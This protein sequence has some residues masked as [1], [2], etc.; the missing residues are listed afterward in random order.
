M[1][2]EQLATLVSSLQN[3]ER[4]TIEPMPEV[5]HP[6][7][8][9]SESPRFVTVNTRAGDIVVE[10]P[11][12]RPSTWMTSDEFD[13]LPSIPSELDCADYT[14]AGIRHQELFTIHHYVP[15]I[16]ELVRLEK[17]SETSNCLGVLIASDINGFETDMAIGIFPTAGGSKEHE[18]IMAHLPCTTHQAMWNSPDLDELYEITG[19]V[20][21]RYITIRKVESVVP[22]TE[23]EIETTE[24]EIFVDEVDVATLDLETL[25][26]TASTPEEAR[27]VFSAEM[28]DH[29]M[30]S[31]EREIEELGN[32]FI[33]YYNNHRAQTMEN[34]H[35][36]VLIQKE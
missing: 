34:L 15:K 21:G 36:A 13:N 24:D 20:V 27:R 2:N 12:D 28:P 26:G 25:R 4:P 35:Q 11:E 32:H 31:R 9:V 17:E 5:E 18:L 6:T 30:I 14:I 23:E 29:C 7:V 33:V 3:G 19:V 10:I 22:V 1:S 16:G 8:T